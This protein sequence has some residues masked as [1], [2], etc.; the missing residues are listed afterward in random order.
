MKNAKTLKC[1]RCK[2]EYTEDYAIDPR[3]QGL[4]FLLDMQPYAHESNR[5]K[6]CLSGVPEDTRCTVIR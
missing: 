6:P 3:D 5:C 2:R 4:D 1:S